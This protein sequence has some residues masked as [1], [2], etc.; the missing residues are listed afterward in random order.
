MALLLGDWGG[1]WQRKKSG[2]C[3]VV[4]T[5]SH[6][7][8]GSSHW[9]E[10][11]VRPATALICPK[12]FFNISNSWARCVFHSQMKGLSFCRMPITPRPE[13]MRT[14]R[15]FSLSSCSRA[16]ACP[17]T[18]HK[19]ISVYNVLQILDS[20]EQD[21]SHCLLV[22]RYRYIDIH[23]YIFLWWFCFSD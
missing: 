3:F 7:F 14:D 5:C 18:S 13:A 19:F 1:C 4:H 22:R 20:V 9:C 15:G 12:S 23:R 8:A 2:W 10:G 6:L 16:P 11:V 21:S 17:C